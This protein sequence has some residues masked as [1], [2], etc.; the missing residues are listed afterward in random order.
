M[1]GIPKSWGRTP[2]DKLAR[3]TWWIMG[4]TLIIAVAAGVANSL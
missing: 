4:M 3:L 1:S 2:Q